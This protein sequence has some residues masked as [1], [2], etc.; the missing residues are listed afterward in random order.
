MRTTTSLS[1]SFLLFCATIALLVS[2]CSGPLS[3]SLGSEEKGDSDTIK[4]DEASK[5]QL[6]DGDLAGTEIDIP[7]GALPAGSKVNARQVNAPDE[8]SAT[9]GVSPASAALRVSA[10]G[11]DGQPIHELSQ[12]MTIQLPLSATTLALAVEKSESNLCALLS[13]SDGSLFVWRRSALAVATGKVTFDSKKLGVFQIVYCGQETLAGFADAQDGDIAGAASTALAV[14]DIPTSFNL[15][16]THYCALVI[17]DDKSEDGA[18]KEDVAYFAFTDIPAD[19]SA[20]QSLKITLTPGT[21]LSDIA[22]D[23]KLM[24][25]VFFQNDTQK[26]LQDGERPAGSMFARTLAGSEMNGGKYGAVFGTDWTFG[27]T[28]LRLGTSSGGGN[29]PDPAA[30]SICVSSGDDTSATVQQLITVADGKIDGRDTAVLYYPLD[31]TGG[32]AP[33]FKFLQNAKSCDGDD[34]EPSIR[35]G[36]NTAAQVIYTQLQSRLI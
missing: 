22:D 16:Q 20:T 15:G 13:S 14:I 3:G 2:G 6:G 27:Q 19:T 34:S 17:K 10:K 24:V 4:A 26:C 5:L 36:D 33:T 35:T 18:E 29:F 9:E 7:A 25:A 32:T 12:P 23:T 30:M 1:M 28:T 21:K 11:P 8:F 31:N